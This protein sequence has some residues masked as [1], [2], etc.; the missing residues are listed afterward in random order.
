MLT[1]VRSNWLKSGLNQFIKQNH[2]QQ[3]RK[4]SS[5]STEQTVT[6]LLLSSNGLLGATGLVTT[7]AAGWLATRYKIA[8]PNEYVVRTGILIEDIDVSKRAFKLPYQTLT[9]VSLEPATYHCTI[10]EAMS[11]ERITF[12]MPTVF[13][14]GPEDDIEQIK[15]YAKFLHTTSTDDLKSKIIGIIQGETRVAAGKVRLDDLF[16]DRNEFKQIIVKNIDSELSQFGLKVYNANIGELKDMV[17]NEYFTY[18]KKKALEGAVNRAK[19]DVAE[20]AKIGNI[21]EKKHLTETR[22]NLADYEKQ[23]KLSEND[24]DREIAES[25]TKLEISKVEFDRQKKIAEYEAAANSEKRKMELQKEVEEYR[26]RQE[27][28]RL[29]A[30]HFAPTNVNAEIA[31]KQAEGIANA[32]KIEAEGKA[33]AMEIE[34][35]GRAAATK[36]QAEAESIAMKM[37]AEAH[38]IEKENEAKGTVKLLGAEAEGFQ[39]LIASGGNVDALIAYLLVKN[40]VL[41][42]IAAEQSKAV[43]GMKPTIWM[44]GNVNEDK[45][46]LSNVVDDLVKTG[47]PLLENLKSSVGIDLLKGFKKEN[48]EKLD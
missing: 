17:G 3:K 43:Q 6:D 42:N 40:N 34:A 2:L 47:V 19:V 31:V 30:T 45:V 13:T 18:M 48:K 24:R 27:V 41:Q 37:K 32:L 1:S 4:Y 9:K 33:L 25:S 16:N 46:R 23:A 26:N 14:I 20:Q 38:Y 39:Q 15:K 35:K 8:G 22:Q 36:L 29:R 11:N 12:G 5:L 10:D 44:T 28:E 21:G 7:M